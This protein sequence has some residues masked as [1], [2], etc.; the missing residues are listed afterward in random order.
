MTIKYDRNLVHYITATAIIVREGKFLIAKRAGWEKAFP[1]KWTVPGGKLKVLDYILR[2]KDTGELWYNI[3][4]DLV[5]REVDEEVG[6]EVENFGYL[7]SMIY[8]RDD[9]VPCIVISLYADAKPGEVKLAP[10]LTEYAW[11]TLEEAKEYDL[12]DGIYEELEMTD[13]IL[14]GEKKTEWKK[15]L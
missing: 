8:I 13:K 15:N 3:L 10:A 1:N 12:I 11:V 4:E 14:K 9:G 5:K 6:L 7:T 2:K